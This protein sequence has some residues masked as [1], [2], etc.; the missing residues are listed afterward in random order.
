MSQDEEI[1]Y[2]TWAFANDLETRQSYLRKKNPDLQEQEI[3]EMVEQLDA[4]SPQQQEANQ[5]QS[6][7][8]RIGE[9]VG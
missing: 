3:T 9:R 5:T 8:D 1:S 6:I 4:E 2:Y 7:L